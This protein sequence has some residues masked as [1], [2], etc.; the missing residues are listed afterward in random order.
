M[1]ASLFNFFQ[2]QQSY[3]EESAKHIASFI[4]SIN[5]ARN[6]NSYPDQ[7]GSFSADQLA[8]KIHTD[9]PVIM[10][11]F[12]MNQCYK[13]HVLA[14]KLKL[15]RLKN[16]KLNRAGSTPFL[17]ETSRIR[18]CVANKLEIIISETEMRIKKLSE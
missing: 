16:C 17:N 9:C 8:K 11:D 6:S 7:Y 13:Q 2:Y 18:R 3:F 4:Q 15:V 10:M 1:H 12:N 5:V 14:D